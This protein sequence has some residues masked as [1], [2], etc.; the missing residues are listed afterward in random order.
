[1]SLYTR[2]AAAREN[3]EARDDAMVAGL[4]YLV[5]H[6]VG[7]EQG[8]NMLSYDADKSVSRQHVEMIR[9]MNEVFPGLVAQF[10]DGS[11]RDTNNNTREA[12][13]YRARYTEITT[14]A[15]EIMDTR[16]DEEGKYAT[17][18]GL[19]FAGAG[20]VVGTTAGVLIHGVISGA[21]GHYVDSTTG[22]K[23]YPGGLKGYSG[24]HRG[25]WYDNGTPAPRFEGLEQMIHT[26]KAGGWNVSDM[27]GKTATTLN[28]GNNTIHPTDF[29]L[30]KIQAVITPRVG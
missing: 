27:L 7:R 17:R 4:S 2:V 28:H 22:N 16:M 26:D 15:G 30:G 29:T 11:L 13:I 18:Q 9:L 25:F 23:Q 20:A 1:M 21:G 19:I 14:L 3:Q 10:N 24:V 12:Q 8:I 5:K 6:L